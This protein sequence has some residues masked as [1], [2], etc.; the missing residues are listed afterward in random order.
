MEQLYKNYG[1]GL[2]GKFGQRNGGDKRY[3]RL[4]QFVGEL[5]GLVII[6]RLR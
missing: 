4:E 5:E 2:Y 1:N 3:V 6:A